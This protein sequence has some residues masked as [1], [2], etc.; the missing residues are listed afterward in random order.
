MITRISTIGM[1]QPDWLLARKDGIGG[2]DVGAVLGMNPYKGPYSVWMDKT[3]RI[4]EQPANLAMRQGT[5]M[6]EF[7][8]QEF[9]T[10]S[11][12]RVHR[13]NAILKNDR[14]PHLHAN[15]DR[16]LFGEKS[17]LE[18][19]TANMMSLRRFSGGEFPESYYAQCVSYLAVTE[20]D[21]WYLC[22]LILSREVR[23]FQLTRIPDDTCPAWCESSTYVSDEEITALVTATSDFWRYVE[24][25]TPPPANGSRDD[26]D[27][28]NNSF[29]VAINT[30]D[31]LELLGAAY[32]LSRLEEIKRLENTL[33]A[34]RK[35]LE[36]GIK[37][38]LGEYEK[39]VC[40]NYKVSWSSRS[41]TTFDAKQFAADHPD[42]DLSNW[43]K[44]TTYRSFAVKR[45]ERN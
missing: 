19:K 23:C 12:K 25:D 17:G 20:Y 1:N 8:A 38:R 32:I 33:S 11:G 27:N 36:N 34:E 18:C 2:S 42:L 30:E 15:V 24:H 5:Y 45:I 7:V 44:T 41:R 16:V 10:L 4:A 26:T 13:V 9:T 31:E 40:E 14:F 21:R 22:V 37:L 29:P 3:N 35:E 43:Y 39:G 6:E 28:L